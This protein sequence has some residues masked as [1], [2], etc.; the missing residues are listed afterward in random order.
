MPKP[1]LLR[2]ELSAVPS[3]RPGLP[4]PSNQ[5]GKAYKLSSNE[6]PYPPSPGV[7]E[8]MVAAAHNANLYPAAA[9]EPL[10]RLLG[11]RLQLTSDSVVVGCGAIGLL[12][13]LIQCAAGP[14]DEVLYAW[15]SFEAYPIFVQ[16]AGA[17]SVAV[18]LTDDGAHDLGAMIRAITSRTRAVLICNPNNPTGNVIDH[19]GLR[20]FLAQVPPELLV[21]LDEAY[22]EF[23]PDDADAQSVELFQNHHNLVLLRTFSKAYGL[24]G[25]RVGYAICHAQVADAL[26]KANDVFSVS[27]IAQ[28]GAA[29]ALQAPAQSE[30]R[31]RVRAVTRRRREL[32]SQLNRLGLT[33]WGEGGNFLWVPLGAASEEFS[34]SL[35]QAGV[36]G[37]VFPGEGVRIS[38]GHPEGDGAVVLAATEH[39]RRRTTAQR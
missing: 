13:H 25:A 10:A 23:L 33:T 14:G 39:L 29:A 12:Q 32:L 7:V 3:Y 21:I 31:S 38:I 37:R 8:A 28:A 6:L 19:V 20:D 26:R 17:T 9:A 22:L 30:M 27:S 34:R 2:P 5:H 36:S 24:A 16:L 1:V 18:P 11:D 15:R 4:A 35:E